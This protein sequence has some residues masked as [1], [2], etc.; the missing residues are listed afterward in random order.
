MQNTKGKTVLSL[1][2]ENYEKNSII[3]RCRILRVKQ[4]YL[5]LQ[6]TKGKKVL[7]LDAEY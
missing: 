1:D 3:F 7:F 6:N 5:Q 2:A 4:Y